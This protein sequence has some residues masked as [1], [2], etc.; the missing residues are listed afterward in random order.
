MKVKFSP[1]FD[2][3]V[4]TGD[5]YQIPS[6]MN[7]SHEGGSVIFRNVVFN[8]IK[9]TAKELQ[10]LAH[11]EELLRMKV[12]KIADGNKRAREAVDY[13]GIMS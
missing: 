1:I 9:R 3:I 7:V 13:M 6:G 10:S 4:S 8:P 5:I 12:A 11:D 2:T